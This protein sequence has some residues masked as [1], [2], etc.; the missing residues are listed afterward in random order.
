MNIN[1]K[2]NAVEQISS[3]GEHCAFTDLIENPFDNSRKSLLCCY[4]R[5]VNHISPDGVVIVCKVNVDSGAK[6][7]QRLA[8]PS[9]DL[10]DPKFCF[11]GRKLIITA[12]AKHKDA[13]TG[14][15]T[16]KMVSYFSTTGDSWSSP[17]FFGHSGWWLWRVTWNKDKA[18]GFAYNR[19]NQRID[20]Y[21]GDPRKQLYLQK[22]GAI[23]FEKHTFGYPNESHILFDDADKATAIVRRDADSF[24]AK[25]GFSSPPYTNWIWHDLKHYVGGPVMLSLTDNMYMVAGRNWDGRNLTTAIWLLSSTDYSLKLLITLPSKGDNSYPGLVWQGDTLY[26]S[27]YSDHIDNKTRVYLATLSGMNGLLNEVEQG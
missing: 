4:R 22:K 9:W 17:H 1:L 8:L 24:S 12:Y 25:L 5:G 21:A 10:R 11:D 18:Y 19:K 20:L 23:S 6:T 14:A 26:V 2:I 7:Y 3:E 15:I 13:N 16:T 27:Y